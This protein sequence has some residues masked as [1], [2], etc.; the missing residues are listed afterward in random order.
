ME[1]IPGSETPILVVDNDVG[2]LLSVKTI[3]VSSGLPEP[4]LVSDSRRVMDL[5]QKYHFHLVLL[6]L[7]MPHLDGMH[8]LQQ[9]KEAFPDTECLVIT[10][11]DEVSSA[12][13]AMRFGAFDYLVKPLQHERLLISINNAL[14]RHSLRQRLSILQTS[15]SFS[16]LKTPS[17]FADMVAKDEGMAVVFHQTET[18]APT[19]YNLVITGETGTGKEML[20][21][22]VH[23]L[24]H[25]SNGPF[26]AV[27]MAASSKTLFEDDFFG[28][29]KG[30]YTGATTEKR[31]FFE[32]AQGG[33]LFMDEIA[34]LAPD[35]QA[36][37]LRVIEER[38]LYQLGG[39]EAKNVDVR[40]VAATN[41]DIRKETEEGRFREDLF[42]RLNGFQIDVPPLRERK[43][44]IL[45]LARHFLKIHAEINQKDI[46]S[47][48]PDLATC[49]LGYPFPGNV[50]E[51]ENIIGSAVLLE[52]DNVL[53]LSCAPEY[54][55]ARAP[56]ETGADELVPLSEVEERHIRHVLEKT[57]GNRTRAAEILGIGLRTLQRKLKAFH[58]AT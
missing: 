27:N 33:T 14:E 15:Q 44:D 35:L 16:N 17:A 55:T 54:L 43:E 50:R 24:S 29:T 8:V 19:E 47:L 40:I 11:T 20:A 12:V 48:A 26:V 3:L 49:L 21:R 46:T 22:I 25:R 31:G 6:D 56:V 36:K 30:A 41:R 38:E 10:A 13:Q 58:K 2:L 9:L 42:Y 39:T 7:V 18:A 37:L 53:T 45:P 4:A 57:G 32:M 51:L 28:H 23:T 1:S 5:V 52:R 34:E